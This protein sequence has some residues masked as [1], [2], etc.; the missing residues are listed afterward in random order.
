LQAGRLTWDATD[1]TL[2]LRGVLSDVDRDAILFS[3]TPNSYLDKLNEL[4]K[5]STEA[6]KPFTVSV[7]LDPPPPG[8][9][10]RYAGFSEK[11]VSYDQETQQLKSTIPLAAKDVKGLMVA[12]S[13]PELRDALNQLMRDS[14]KFRVSLWWLVWFYLLST[15][16]ELCLSPV[17]LSMVSK[18][19]PAKYAT[20]LMG[21]WLVVTSLGNFLAGAMGERY[22][23]VPPTEYFLTLLIALGVAALLLY[24][25]VR[26]I[27]SMMHGVT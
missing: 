6:K 10:L 1:Q 24:F 27:G 19:S 13:N 2:H 25:L 21:L 8:L 22:G 4:W 11:A 20:M 16:G 18:L 3:T 5:A 14:T 15:L 7:K 26:K 17:G 23:S 9:D 12:G